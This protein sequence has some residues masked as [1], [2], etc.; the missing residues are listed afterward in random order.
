[1]PS[2]ASDIRPDKNVSMLFKS[3]PGYGKTIAACSLAV[4]GDV[5][6]AYFD[7]KTPVEVFN[8]Y[9]QYRPELLDRIHY[10]A[11]TAA[12]ANKYLNDLDNI[13]NREAG[14]YIGTITDSV[15][16]LTTASINWS[17]GFRGTKGSIENTLAGS[18]KMIPGFDDYKVE[19]NYAAQALDMTT[20]YSGFNIWTAHPLTSMDIKG[21]GGKI[22]NI[23]TK[24]TLVSYGNKVGQLVPGRF[25]EIYHF[26]R[27]MDKRLVFTDAVGEDYAKTSYFGMPKSLDITDKLF[28][29]VWKAAVDNCLK[30]QEVRNEE[31]KT[32]TIAQVNKWMKP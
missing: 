13:C 29:E 4:F 26:G 32:D 11:Y 17:M 24:Q 8:F 15:T 18:E 2:K 22:D 14:R 20:S 28:F 16:S 25:Q 1:M 6:L 31:V 27:Q 12:N 21:S 3:P 30:M 5:W 10:D 23:S 7:K 9:K 19:T